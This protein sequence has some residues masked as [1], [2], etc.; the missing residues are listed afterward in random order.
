MKKFYVLLA[1]IS[2]YF[3]FGQASDLYFSMYGE[4]SG[5]NK[6]LEIYNGTGAD[7]DL[8]IYSVELYAN[9]ATEATNTLQLSGTL[10]DGE[11][12]VIS[13]SDADQAILDVA[14]TT[15]TVCYFNG[16]DA[17]ALLKNGS[18]L[19]VIGVIGED[20]GSA[21][22]VA[23]VSGA[24]K[25]H[26]LVRKPSVCD[27]TTDWA[28]SA[29]TNEEDSQWIVLGVDEGWGLLGSHEGCVQDPI[30]TITFP[31][32]GD[33]FPPSTTELEATFTVENFNVAEPP[34]GDGYII[35]ALN[36]DENSHYSTDPITLSGLTGGTSYTLAMK[37]VDND[38]NDLNPAVGDTVTFEI[39]GYTQVANLSE[40]RSQDLGGYYEVT[41]EVIITGKIVTDD[42][43]KLYVQDDNAGILIYDP[44]FYIDPDQY[45]LYDG[46]TN[47]KG[48]LDEFREV[49]ELIP[50]ES[51]DAPSSSGNTVTPVE[52]SIPDFVNNVDTYESMLIKFLSV[53][54]D[55]DGETTFS[56][57]ANY[58]VY[59]ADS[60]SVV[61]RTI[62]PDMAGVEIPEGPVDLIGIAGQY[63]STPQ[64]YPRSA[65]D[66]IINNLII[67]SDI[68]GLTVFPNPVTDQTLYISTR[69]N[70]KK[71]I[72]FMDL[73]SKVVWETVMEQN[74]KLVVPLPAGM[75]IMQVEENGNTGSVKLLIK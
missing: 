15:S 56:S 20:P 66:I 75:Y 26:T 35:Y 70:G 69:Q 64:I 2:G 17:V 10:P 49:L 7:V 50:T 67:K 45:S 38:G 55:G 43:V 51:Y 27:P 19:D 46:L 34:A 36:G 39:S 29:G 41:G 52:L 68:D 11:V 58:T 57:Y 48:Q 44:D 21:W 74:G 23:G 31:S 8:S 3:M 73:S 59:D 63:Y 16:D 47:I 40:L 42:Y 30:L 24:T 71:H 53:T 6:F 72:R 18:P 62:F 65:D 12:Y 14:D 32:E 54:I 25:D 13:H 9:G 61:L 22:D 1:L 4:G 5:N 33:I 37:L 28:L 60:N